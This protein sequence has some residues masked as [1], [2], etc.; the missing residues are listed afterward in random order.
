VEFKSHETLTG[1]VL[2]VMRKGTIKIRKIF[3]IAKPLP[4]LRFI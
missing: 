3:D 1:C 4:G 2:P